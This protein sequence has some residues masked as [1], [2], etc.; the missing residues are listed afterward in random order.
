MKMFELKCPYCG[1][2][3]TVDNGIDSFYCMHCGGHI[4]LDELDDNATEL[5]LKA[6]EVDLEKYKIDKTNEENER[7]RQ[8]EFKK[9]KAS[10]KNDLILICICFGF[11]ILV[12]I[13]GAI[14]GL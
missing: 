1:A 4:L 14:T 11:F 7:R 2:D 6:Q 13:Y 3:L 8:H 12:A 10:N 9:E 5:K